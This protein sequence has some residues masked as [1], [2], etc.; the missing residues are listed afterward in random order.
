MSSP[1]ITQTKLLLFRMAGTGPG[2]SGRRRPPTWTRSRRSS[3]VRMRPRWVFTVA[4]ATNSLAAISPLDSPPATSTRISRSRS[5]SR[6]TGR[7]GRRL[8][9]DP[10]VGELG[11]VGVEQAPGDAGGDHG[12]A[13]RHRTDGRR[14]LGGR[15]VLEQEAA[16]PEAQGGEGVLV[17][18]EGGQDEHPRRGGLGHHPPGGL[19]PVHPRHPHVHQDHVGPQLG[20]QPRP[21]PPRRPPRRPPGGPPAPRGSCGTR[22]G[23]APGRRRAGR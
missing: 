2:R 17:E 15:H 23:A 9:A 19:D 16:G 4:S 1:E 5:V 7:P 8:G 10:Q 13:R 20:G 12:V 3:L 6:S 21:P 18:V 14:Q 22:C 11:R